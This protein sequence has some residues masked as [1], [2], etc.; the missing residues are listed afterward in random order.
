MQNGSENTVELRKLLTYFELI[1]VIKIGATT[2]EILN[3]FRL[4]ARSKKLWSVFC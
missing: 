2:F 1:F 4:L 3:I